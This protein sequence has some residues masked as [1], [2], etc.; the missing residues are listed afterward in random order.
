MR[1]LIVTDAFPPRA[2][3][4]GWSTYELART[5]RLRGHLVVVVRP[6][7]DQRAPAVAAYDG[8]DV[9]QPQAWAPPVPFVRNY[10]KNE[11]LYD[12]LSRTLEVIIRDQHIDVVHGQ[13]LLTGPAAVRAAERAGVVSVCTVRDYW[14]VCYWSDLMINPGSAELCPGCSGAHM[15][16]CVKPRG[17]WLW[18]LGLAAIPYMQGNLRRKQRAL[19]SANAI[20]A[21]SHRMAADL[22]AR[23][24]G[25][26][27][28]RIDVIPNPVDVERLQAEAAH[29]PVSTPFPGPYALYVGKLAPNKGSL[30]LLDVA[31]AA[32]LDWPVVVVGDGPLRRVMEAEAKARNIN[33]HFTGWLDRPDVLAWL[34]HAS[35]L[36][37]PSAWPEPFSRVLL[38]ASALGVPTAA[39]DTGGTSEIVVDGVTGLL[40]GNVPDLASAVG[41]LRAGPELRAR[42]GRAAARHVLERFDSAAVVPRVEALYTELSEARDSSPGGTR[43]HAGLQPL[44]QP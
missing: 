7:F 40:A 16:I 30:R 34:Q 36:V 25:I 44:K 22:R 14:P 9:L 19:A 33:L 13:H 12:R 42:L 20:V 3:G 31:S 37:F 8:F 10:F 35:I 6:R 18:P 27:T 2:G 38:E 23:A 28:A 1:I 15:A 26:S 41:R 17:G 32:R 39:M 43:R 4:S 29:A 5:L 11:R 24:A 21:V